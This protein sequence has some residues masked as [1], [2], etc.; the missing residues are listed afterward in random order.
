[1]TTNSSSQSLTQKDIKLDIKKIS[2]RNKILSD[3]SDTLKAKFIGIDR[4]IDELIDIL[5]VWYLMPEI[6]TRPVII[7]L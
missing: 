2:A 6:L 5:R 3:A 4:V 7:N 1:M